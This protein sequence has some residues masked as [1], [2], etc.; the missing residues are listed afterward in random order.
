MRRLAVAIAQLAALGFALATLLATTLACRTRDFDRGYAATGDC[1]PAGQ[2][3]ISSRQCDLHL[4]GVPWLPADGSA[5]PPRSFDANGFNAWGEVSLT[6]PLN[7]ADGTPFTPPGDPT[8]PFVTQLH[9]RGT[10]SGTA[11]GA[12]DLACE[13]PDGPVCGGALA[14]LP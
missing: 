8:G 10:P 14:P 5:G 7:L 4:A 11:P 13:S 9:C 12:F 2:V 6:P 3:T 1:G